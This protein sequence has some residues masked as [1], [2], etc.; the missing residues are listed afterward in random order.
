MSESDL[1]NRPSD[2]V[3][4]ESDL[5]NRH[6]DLVNRES[7]LVHRESDLVNCTFV[8]L[9]FSTLYFG[10]PYKQPTTKLT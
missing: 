9:L 10:T 2:L 8:V 7:D 1:V 6:S 5:V 3:N 4:R